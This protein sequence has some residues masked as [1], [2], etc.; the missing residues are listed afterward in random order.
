MS[1]RLHPQSVKNKNTKEIKYWDLFSLHLFSIL[2][3][4][5]GLRI[6]V[7]NCSP[8]NQR[9]KLFGDFC[10]LPSHPRLVQICC[11]HP[12]NKGVH[13]QT[14]SSP[15]FPIYELFNQ[16]MSSLHRCHAD[17][18]HSHVGCCKE[19]SLQRDAHQLFPSWIN[20]SESWNLSTLRKAALVT[21]NS[22][23]NFSTV[24]YIF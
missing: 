23:D 3:Q 19:H 20:R 11:E 4:R 7:K 8:S 14:Q 15:P 1:Y 2:K 21:L 13:H 16:F 6:G 12:G 10:L 5:A 9:K 24:T 22:L 18:Y 17:L